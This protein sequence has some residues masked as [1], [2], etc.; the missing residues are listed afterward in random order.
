M[1]NTPLAFDAHINDWCNASKANKALYKGANIYKTV[2]LI[3]QI[4]LMVVPLVL[5]VFTFRKFTGTGS[6]QDVID[7]AKDTISLMKTL[8][9]I[10]SVVGIL[11]ALYYVIDT[12]GTY[13]FGV[14]MN[15]NNVNAIPALEQS[16]DIKLGSKGK[17]RFRKTATAASLNKNG[18]I[19]TINTICSLMRMV[20]QILIAIAII[21]Y[22][23][24]TVLDNFVTILD[25]TGGSM[26]IDFNELIAGYKKFFLF[27][28]IAFVLGIAESILRIVWK[29][30]C[31]SWIRSE[32]AKEYNAQV[33]SENNETNVAENNDAD[34]I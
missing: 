24:N 15:S 19:I 33:E 7:S 25:K 32:V 3:I 14:W 30:T 4:L 28:I 13:K 34:A 10:S 5:L 8:L 17:E 23:A 21:S 2:T 9:I 18:S 11:S 6:A 26:N 29:T 1:A 27:I 22:V 20:S 16:V 12:I 31:F